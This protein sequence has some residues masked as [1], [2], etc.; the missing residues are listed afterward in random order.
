[1]GSNDKGGLVPV[2]GQRDPEQTRASLIEWLSRQIP[3]SEHVEIDNLVVPQSSG[4]S[5]ETFLFDASWTLDGT[6]QRSELVLRAQPQ[7]WAVFPEIDVINQQY[8]SMKILGAHSDVPV[9]T[10]R[11]AESDRDVLGTPFFVMD[12]MHGQVPGD[13]PPY[14]VEG[15]FVDLTDDQRR[16][17]NIDGLSAMTK[18]NRVDWRSLDFGYLDRREY[19]PLGR[20]QRLGYFDKFWQW[21]R[22]G[23]AHPVADPAWEYIRDH[24]PAEEPVELC[25]GDARPGNQMYANGRCVAV[26]D[27]EMVSL[28]NAVSDLGWWLFLQRFHTE[29]TGVP[30]PGGML[31]RDETIALWEDRVGRTAEHVDFYEIVAGFH[32]TLVMMRIVGMFKELDPQSYSPGGDIYNPVSMLTAQMLG[33]ELRV[34]GR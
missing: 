23:N 21:A 9:A 33:I 7:V 15:W 17:L 19:G 22:A 25:W 31:T 4:F 30:L 32:F 20:A 12:R 27:W 18:V 1:L 5:N 8:R 10:V 34:P 16:E 13:R 14:T 29:G 3:G 26:M 11:W 2:G 28:G 6:N 24:W